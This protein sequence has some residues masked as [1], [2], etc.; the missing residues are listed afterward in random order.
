MPAEEATSITSGTS[1]SVR[2]RWTIR[3]KKRLKLSRRHGISGTR[4]P[5]PLFAQ[6]GDEL[7]APQWTPIF[8][9]DPAQAIKSRKAILDRV[10]TDRVMVM[11]Y[12][13]PFPVIGHVVRHDTAYRWET[14]QWAW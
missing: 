9:Y 1:K 14:A 6:S 11:D 5:S 12:H 3:S 8:D 7:A 13:F 10:A 4:G 2:F